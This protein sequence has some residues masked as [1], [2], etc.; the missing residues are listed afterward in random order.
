MQIMLDLFEVQLDVPND[1]CLFFREQRLGKI[2]NELR[3]IQ[4]EESALFDRI[5]LDPISF[6]DQV[7]KFELVL[8]QK[9]R[10]IFEVADC[11]VAADVSKLH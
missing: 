8:P 1:L 9:C 2:V 6:F 10:D 5:S 3:I 11:C 4:K 7:M